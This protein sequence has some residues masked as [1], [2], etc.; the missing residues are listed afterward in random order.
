MPE[1]IFALDD[2]AAIQRDYFADLRRDGQVEADPSGW[3]STRSPSEDFLEFPPLE[4]QDF[5]QYYLDAGDALGEKKER[6]AHVLSAWDGAPVARDAFTICPSG[7]LAS[8]ST[9]AVLKW[10]GVSRILF[11]TPCFYGTVEQAHE[12]NLETELIPTYR[13]DEYAMPVDLGNTNR[14][15]PL[16]LWLTQPRGS[17]GF[18]QDRTIIERWIRDLRPDDFIVIDE[19][20]EQ[21]FPA[22]MGNLTLDKTNIV[23]LRSFTKGMGLN[24]FRL[25]AVMHPP[26]LRSMFTE[27]VELFGGTVDA[28]SLL[29]TCALADD[30]DRFKMMLAAANTQVNA[31][32]Q[33]AE[34]A[35]RGSMVHVNHL[36]NGYIGSMAANLS[37]LGSTHEA[38]RYNFLN[39]CRALRTPVTLGASFYLA[40]D[41]PFEAVR[42]NFFMT[43]QNVLGGIAN[44]MS[45]LNG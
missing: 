31:L 26:S 9:L 35:S 14:D 4:R 39:R 38:R 19:V 17:L 2:Y 27:S 16:S 12:L 25:S 33:K 29:S 1:A 11:E 44:V 20:T 22:R 23:R 5:A 45:I 36:V 30:I 15:G 8:L 42:I 13:R 40:K 43:D 7:A 41:P 18:N 37:N 6:I 3:L 32:R 24:G 21:A 10:R 28:Y 34:R